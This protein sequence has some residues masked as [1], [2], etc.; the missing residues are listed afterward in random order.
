[1]TVELAKDLLY[2]VGSLAWLI[3]TAL[4]MGRRLGWW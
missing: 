1:M 2:L 4:G 3:A